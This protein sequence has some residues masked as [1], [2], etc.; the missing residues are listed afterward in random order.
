MARSPPRLLRH[1]PVGVRRGGDFSTGCKSRGQ[2]CFEVPG[3]TRKR[4]QEKLPDGR[5]GAPEA[6][7]G[8]SR[9]LAQSGFGNKKGPD[10]SDPFLAQERTRT[11]TLLPALDPESSV[12]TNSTTWAAFTSD[13]CIGCSRCPRQGLNQSPFAFVFYKGLP[14]LSVRRRRGRLHRPTASITTTSEPERPNVSGAYISSAR[15]GGTTK[16]PGVVARAM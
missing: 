15:V 5:H 12:S 3:P 4:R 6:T 13:V 16:V 11:S 14:P 9:R 7:N 8:D 1:G 10:E 2:G